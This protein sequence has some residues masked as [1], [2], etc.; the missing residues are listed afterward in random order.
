[1]NKLL[2]ATML[3][4]A[5]LAAP[6]VHADDAYYI[7]AGIS[8]HGTL[9]LDG[10]VNKNSPQPYSAYAG[11]GLNEHFAL[12]AGY[13]SFGKYKF[14]GP[15]SIDLSALYL[16]GK[17]SIK[18]GESWSLYAKAGVARYAMDV[19]FNPEKDL[20]KLQPLIGVGF[21]YRITKDIALGLEYNDFHSFK[22]R[23]GKITTRQLQA[24]VKYSF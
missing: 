10:E 3:L 23:T 20:H 2:C 24:T 13:M 11:Y 6:A 17:G 22:T 16:A 12:E 5:T 1:M 18:L 8:K 14:S 4:A 19:N 21:D 9:Y 7:G 15:A